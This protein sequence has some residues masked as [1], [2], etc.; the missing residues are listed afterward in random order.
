MSNELY[1]E[2]K[3]WEPHAFDDEDWAWR[4]TPVGKCF[5]EKEDKCIKEG[6]TY[7]ECVIEA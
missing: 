3:Y 7:R 2:Y 5:L 1:K 4:K 6:G